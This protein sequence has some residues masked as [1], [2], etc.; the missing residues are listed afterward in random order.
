[1]LLSSRRK[2][3]IREKKTRKLAQ[4]SIVELARGWFSQYRPVFQ[5]LL[6]FVVLM[7]LFYVFIAFMPFYKKHL[8]P[9]H[10]HLIARLSGAILA[11]LGQDITVVGA[12]I[13]SPAL[14]VHIVWGCDA[15]EA[16]ALFVFAVLAFPAPFLRKIPGIIAG[17]LFLAI[18]NFIRVV[19]L[20]LIG[21]YFPRVFAIMHIDVWQSMFIFSAI[22]FWGFWLLWA[23]Q[24]Q[25]PTQRVSS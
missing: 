9:S 23:T 12:F 25:I 5:F 6:I 20:F 13:S 1:L 3:T 11:F 8:L 4:K 14:S 19:S 16:I 24:S 10:H 15:I 17:T 22:I 7:G 18:L 2:K 21:V